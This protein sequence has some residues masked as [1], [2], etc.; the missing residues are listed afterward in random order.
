MCVKCSFLLLLSSNKH[1]L[2]L[3]VLTLDRHHTQAWLSTWTLETVAVQI[4]HISST[5][6]SS[7]DDTDIIF[8]IWSLILW[9][10]SFSF[11]HCMCFCVL[12]TILSMTE[13]H[14]CYFSQSMISV[15]LFSPCFYF[16][17]LWCNCGTSR[18][19]GTY[20]ITCQM[21]KMKTF[22]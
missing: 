3:I 16:K 22:V 17:C 11:H 20:S 14:L 19:T 10:S 12:M 8:I 21:D 15:T 4:F 2:K 1:E 7:D 6:F 13:P 5:M 18:S 9:S